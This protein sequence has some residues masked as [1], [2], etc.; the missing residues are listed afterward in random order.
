MQQRLGFG[1]A[2]INTVNIDWNRFKRDKHIFDSA[3]GR[4]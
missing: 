3:G 1:R 2:L 4:E